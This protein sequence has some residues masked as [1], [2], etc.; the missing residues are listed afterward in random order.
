MLPIL[1]GLGWINGFKL[2]IFPWILFFTGRFV[3]VVDEK[4]SKQSNG[5][6][7]KVVE[8][9]AARDEI[10]KSDTLKSSSK[11]LWV[12]IEKKKRINI[13][14]FKCQWVGHFEV[15]KMQNNWNL[16]DVYESV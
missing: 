4:S 6:L 10:L 16:E 7:E 15:C 12:D 5:S 8:R 14:L 3:V 1:T 13:N 2:R 9:D 11:P